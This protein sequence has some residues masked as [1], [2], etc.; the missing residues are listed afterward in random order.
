[1]CSVEGES[2]YV[3]GRGL[4]GEGRSPIAGVNA[5][6]FVVWAIHVPEIFAIEGQVQAT[7]AG[8]HRWLE[9]G[10]WRTIGWVEHVDAP[11]QVVGLVEQAKAVVVG[12]SVGHSLSREAQEFHTGWAE[13][14]D[15]VIVVIH[16][17]SSSTKGQP[18]AVCEGERLY[19]GARVGV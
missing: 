9:G 1:M 4:K 17:E 10:D 5:I 7:G 13:F 15:L 19:D 18:V 6:D 8:I 3:G 14:A 16:P 11:A 12:E 2:L